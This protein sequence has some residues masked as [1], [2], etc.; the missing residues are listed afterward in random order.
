[1]YLACGRPGPMVIKHLPTECYTCVGYQMS[2]GPQRYVTPKLSNGDVAEFWHA[3]FTKNLAGVPEYL[4]VYWSWSSDGEWK[5]P[6]RPRLVWPVGK[7]P[8]LYKLYVIRK[9]ESEK[10]AFEGSPAHDFIE[11][12]VPELKRSHFSQP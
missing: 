10:E 7:V 8:T 6:D 9:L 1:M 4:R 11:A 2:K 5:T 12:F 3:L